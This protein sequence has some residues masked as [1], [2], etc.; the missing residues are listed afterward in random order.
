MK[1]IAFVMVAA[2][3]LLLAGV[4]AVVVLT[5]DGGTGHRS[6]A[7]AV[8]YRCPMHPA[9]TSDSPGDCPICGMKLAPMDDASAANPATAPGV[10]GGT[11]QGAAAEVR[12]RVA[13]AISAERRQLLGVRSEPV[14]SIRLAH[15]IRTV[16]RVAVDERR[17]HHIHTKYDGYVEHLYVDYTGKLVRRGERLLSIYSPELVA[18]QEEYLLALR[19]QSNLAGSAVR[20]AAQGSVDLR[21]AARQRLLLWD[22]RPADIEKLEEAG[23]VARTVDVYAEIGGHVVEKMA[24]QG[25]R[26]T[27]A[28]TLYDIAD[29]SHLWVLADVYEYTLPSLTLGTEGRIEV[30]SIPGRHWRG[31]VTYISPTVEEKTRTIKVRLEVD[32]TSGTLKPGMYADVFLHVDLGDGLVVPEAAVIN[33]GD[34]HLVFLDRGE[35]RFEPREVKLGIKVNGDGVQVLSG[36]VEGH[37]VVTSA[38]FLIDS[39]SSLKAALAGMSASDSPPGKS[40]ASH[41]AGAH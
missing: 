15:R 22:I 40:P 35:G 18:T 12:G 1:R 24:Y 25:M 29:L 41:D 11:P 30:A 20:S 10:E 14:K 4:T 6:D 37:Q 26:V 21:E 33:A 28:D 5:R 2:G 38:N 23:Q 36:L 32:N 34:R 13:V 7:K 19:A 3:A 9:Y 8:R 31:A 17:L 39:E 16:G 27:P